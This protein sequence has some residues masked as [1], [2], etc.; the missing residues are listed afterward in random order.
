MSSRERHIN[1][2]NKRKEVASI[3][4]EEMSKNMSKEIGRPVDVAELFRQTHVRKDIGE[5]VDDR[6]RR[7][8]SLEK[9]IRKLDFNP[10][11]AS[12]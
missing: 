1:T 3:T 6:A 11:I 8:Y 7:T 12:G 2:N 5:F 4:Y 9:S 10:S